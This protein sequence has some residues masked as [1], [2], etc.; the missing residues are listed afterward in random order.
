MNVLITGGTGFIGSAL[1]SLLLKDKH[2]VVVLS[3]HPEKIKSPLRGISDLKQLV[4]DTFFDVVIN[5]AGEPIA[6]KKWSDQQKQKIIQSR[7][8]ITQNL[9]SYFEAMEHRPTLFIS[10]SAIGYYGIT[11][12]DEGIDET[13][14]GDSSFSSQLCQQWES[15]ALQAQKMGIRTCIIRT[16]IVLGNGGALGKML[17]PFKMGL[18]GIIGKGSQWMSWVHLHDLLG[19]IL[20]CIDHAEMQGV[21]NGTSPHP[22]TNR[23]FTKTLSDVL[24]R[25]S[26]LP[27]PAFVVKMLMG[28][29]GEELLLAGK[30]VLP[31]KV[32]NAGYIFKY[33]QLKGALQDVVNNQG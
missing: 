33:K 24:K 11:A 9:I 10:G 5:L 2:D 18:G 23:V 25:P 1:C 7:I 3:R 19:I 16:G 29:M 28:Q 12:S 6:D 4:S 17:L 30:K 14:S 8:N 32:L 20:Y 26:F 15:L 31:V 27:M 21:I 13:V 22:V